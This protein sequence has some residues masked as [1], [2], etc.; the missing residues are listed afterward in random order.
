LIQS[1]ILLV[2]RLATFNRRRWI[3]ENAECLFVNEIE[4]NGNQKCLLVLDGAHNSGGQ[5]EP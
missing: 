2:D 4:I 3:V 1:D 5:H